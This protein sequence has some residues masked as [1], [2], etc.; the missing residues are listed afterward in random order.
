M[1]YVDQETRD[2][3]E[4]RTAGTSGELN[5]NVTRLLR[6][7]LGANPS[8]DDFNTAIG[9]LECAKLELY[10]RLIVPYED[11]KIIDNG[12]V[13]DGPLATDSRPVSPIRN[14]PP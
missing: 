8:Y 3:L 11:S 14:F 7:F 1:P 5:F 10:R 13:Y 2:E 4:R 9:V 6:E 12:D